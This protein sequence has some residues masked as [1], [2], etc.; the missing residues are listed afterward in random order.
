MVSLDSIDVAVDQ[1]LNCSARLTH[2]FHQRGGATAG[3]AVCSG[4]TSEGQP[5]WGSPEKLSAK[6]R[7]FMRWLMGRC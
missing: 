2:R 1:F 4:E 6:P 7:D 5:L 3:A